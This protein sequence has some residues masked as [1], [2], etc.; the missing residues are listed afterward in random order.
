MAAPTGNNI[1]PAAFSVPHSHR[2]GLVHCLRTCATR[3]G[4]ARTIATSGSAWHTLPAIRT[5]LHYDMDCSYDA[6]HL[7]PGNLRLTMS[8]RIRPTCKRSTYIRT[9]SG[10]VRIPV[11]TQQLR[12]IQELHLW[13]PSVVSYLL[14]TCGAGCRA[15]G[16]CL[17]GWCHRRIVIDA[18][19]WKGLPSK[20]RRGAPCGA[21]IP[22]EHVFKETG[23]FRV[24]QMEQILNCSI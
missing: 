4:G 7:V 24:P 21:R 19:H 23:N 16:A 11:S 1:K 20:T 8:M 3:G 14:P 12:N 2:F 5:D 9:G 15:P 10:T 17:T 18:A 6:V 22:Y 13:V